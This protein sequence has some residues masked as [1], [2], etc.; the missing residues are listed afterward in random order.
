VREDAGET[1]RFAITR[2]DTNQ[3]ALTI[4]YALSGTATPGVDNQ[5]GGS[6]VTIPAGF[7]SVGLALTPVADSL[8]EGDEPIVLTLTP[9]ATYSIDTPASVQTVLKDRPLDEWRFGSFSASERANPAISG[10]VADPDK[11]G[12]PNLVEYAFGTD[13]MRANAAPLSSAVVRICGWLIALIVVFGLLPAIFVR[14][15][16]SG[17]LTERAP[18]SFRQ[19]LRESLRCGPLW[20]SIGV[21]F[22]LVLGYSSVGAP[23]QNVNFY[24]ANDGDIAK[25]AMI[26]GWRGTVTGLAGVS[27]ILLFTGLGSKYD[28]RTMVFSMLGLSVGGHLLNLLCMTPKHPYLQIVPA[29]FEA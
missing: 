19:G 27:S 5:G 25:G 12:S 1:V 18:E 4:N 28:K 15:R 3:N 10:D 16:A 24:Y 7:S 11:D 13:P 17:A 8:S 6:A 2:R 21:S 20:V 29:A 26:A 23:G 14:D 22:F 9:D